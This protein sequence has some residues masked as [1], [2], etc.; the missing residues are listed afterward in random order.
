MFLGRNKSLN[1]GT[2]LG[3]AGSPEVGE[4]TQF[5]NQIKSMPMGIQRFLSKRGINSSADLAN[6]VQYAPRMPFRKE[7]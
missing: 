2:T 6:R 4:N 3:E 1:Q 7:R 5:L